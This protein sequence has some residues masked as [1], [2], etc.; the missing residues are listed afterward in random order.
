M[1]YTPSAFSVVRLCIAS[2]FFLL[3]L[4]ATSAFGQQPQVLLGKTK[5]GSSLGESQSG[6]AKAFPVRAVATGQVDSLSVYLD[7]SN[8][9][10][11]VWVGMYTS[12]HGHPQTLL[13]KGVISNPIS[14]Q[15]NSVSLPPAQVSAGA[16][17]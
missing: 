5:V 17:Y 2:P 8:E 10:P 1:S 6:T 12:H 14:G 16:T 15:W 11:T 7:S 3:I 4:L 9:A 13:S